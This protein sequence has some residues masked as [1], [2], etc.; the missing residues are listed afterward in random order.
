M[1]GDPDRDVVIVVDSA[2]TRREAMANSFRTQGC[3]VFRFFEQNAKLLQRPANEEQPES[4]LILLWHFGDLEQEW[5][6]IGATL[7]VYYG[8]NGGNDRRKPKKAGQRIWRRVGSKESVLNEEEAK[9]LVTYAKGLSSGARPLPTK[10]SFLSLPQKVYALSTLAVLCKGYL[11][12]HAAVDAMKEHGTV[13]DFDTSDIREALKEIGWD[14]LQKNREALQNM[15]VGLSDHFILV[16][17]SEWWLKPCLGGDLGDAGSSQARLKK[18]AATAENE[19]MQIHGIVS[20]VPEEGA[21]AAKPVQ[22]AFK[23]VKTLLDSIEME[24]G[25]VVPSVVA[26]AYLDL[27]KVLKSKGRI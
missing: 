8:G 14:E 24:N 26:S 23:H 3:K 15:I 10:P 19:W 21:A 9:Q 6:A 11:A 22:D 17:S 2:P 27:C 13:T 5:P 7:T 25:E 18:F 20:P 1:A 12:V 16:R 4:C